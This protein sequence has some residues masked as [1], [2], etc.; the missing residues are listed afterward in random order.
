MSDLAALQRSLNAIAAE[1]REHVRVGPFDAY[2]DRLREPK[3][4]SFALP[5][6]G[7]PDAAMTAALPGLREAFAARG[8]NARTEFIETLTPGLEALLVA[9]GWVLSE[10][11]P[12]MTCTP[13]SC[14]APP[15]SR[16]CASRSSAPRSPEEEVLGFLLAQREAFLDDSPITDEELLRWRA[17]AATS[18]HAAGFLGDQIA[19]T[20]FASA[21]VDGITEIGGVATPPRFR[22]RGIASAVTGAVTAAGFAGG[23]RLAWLTAAGD[24]SRRIYERAG[25]RSEGTL[26][27]YDAPNPRPP[28]TGP[29]NGA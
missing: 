18:F 4:Y 12:V 19:G 17:R 27:A 29:L 28:S 21:V 5:A 20:A 2:V 16:V 22:R 25:F 15:W 11:M 10:R 1:D 7:A 6:P 23:A 24:D 9:D 26:L 8:R 3:Y 14:E 13:E